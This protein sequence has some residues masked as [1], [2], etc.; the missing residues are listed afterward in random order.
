MIYYIIEVYFL[1]FFH[2]LRMAETNKIF[3]EKIT[4]LAVANHGAKDVL[5]MLAQQNPSLLD[6][7]EEQLIV[8]SDLWRLYNDICKQSV[9]DLAKVLTDGTAKQQLAES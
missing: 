4:R 8:G 9:D 3:E 5:N 1:T 2:L 6:M 7:C